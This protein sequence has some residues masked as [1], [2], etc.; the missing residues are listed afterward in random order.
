MTALSR[1]QAQRTKRMAEKDASKEERAA[2]ARHSAEE[3]AAEEEDALQASAEQQLEE[4]K[5]AEQAA[6]RRTAGSSPSINNQIDAN[7]GESDNGAD[8]E[9]SWEI[10]GLS[11][12]RVR[13]GIT[14]YR[15]DWKPT[16]EETFE[17]TWEPKD[18]IDDTAIASYEA[19][20][21]GRRGRGRRSGNS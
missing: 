1:R 6:A 7:E 9:A 2:A 13:G 21:G 17:P 15:V 12:K 16:K 8:E 5:A 10:R 20:S 19:S 14:E 4:E 18:L 11:G 3:E